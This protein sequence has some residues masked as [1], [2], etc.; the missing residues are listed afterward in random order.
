MIKLMHEYYD[1]QDPR[2]YDIYNV[3]L[4]HLKQMFYFVPKSSDFLYGTDDIEFKLNSRDGKLVTTATVKRWMKELPFK[5]IVKR[6]SPHPRISSFYEY[7][8]KIDEE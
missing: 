5:T 2:L 6:S 3:V 7:Y 8:I 4:S 1:R